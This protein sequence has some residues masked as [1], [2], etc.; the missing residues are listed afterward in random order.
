MTNTLALWIA[1]VIAACFAV[2][3]ILFDWA[4]SL[5]LALRFRDLL[6]WMAF[7]R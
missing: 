5:F 2:D 3:A 6:G 7:W 4:G 1:A